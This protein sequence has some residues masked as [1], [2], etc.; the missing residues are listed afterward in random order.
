MFSRLLYAETADEP[1]G[2]QNGRGTEWRGSGGLNPT[3]VKKIQ[4]LVRG[5]KMEDTHPS[6]SAQKTTSGVEGI[7][8]SACLCNY[9]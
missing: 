3:R 8:P 7:T 2:T 1:V 6:F 5:Y 9:R 4:R